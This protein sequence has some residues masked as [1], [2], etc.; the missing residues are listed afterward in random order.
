VAIKWRALAAVP[1]KS[2]NNRVYSEKV[3]RETVGQWEG[4]PFLL[5]HD[6]H[7]VR[8][9]CVGIISHSNYGEDKCRDGST[10]KGL[11][12]EGFG[13]VSKPLFE[14]MQDNPQYPAIV[15]STSI[16]AAGEG[17]MFN[18]FGG[19]T[20]VV[21]DRLMPEEFSC[22]SIPGIPESHLASVD[23]IEEAYRK[24][25][26]FN[27]G[28]TKLSEQDNRTDGNTIPG[29]P[30]A[31]FLPLGTG[32]P[33]FNPPPTL[34]PTDSTTAQHAR[35]ARGEECFRKAPLKRVELSDGSVVCYQP[36]TAIEG[37]RP[38]STRRSELPS[39][40][41]NWRGPNVL[42]Q[43]ETKFPVDNT[44]L[45]YD[46]LTHKTT[47]VKREQLG[48]GGNTLGALGLGRMS[49]QPPA[50]K[51]QFG[52]MGPAGTGP[53]QPRADT[54]TVMSYGQIANMAPGGKMPP[55]PPVKPVD[56]P[57]TAKSMSAGVNVGAIGGQTPP[58]DDDTTAG[59][60]G[61][62]ETKIASSLFYDPEEYLTKEEEEL[63]DEVFSIPDE[64]WANFE[65]DAIVSMAEGSVHEW[66][67]AKKKN[68]IAGAI[69]HP[70]ALRKA[71]GV[72][73]DEPIPVSRLQ[74]AAK[75]KDPKMRRRAI[76]A[77]TLRKLHRK[78]AK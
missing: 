43:E 18:T 71:L 63:L 19:D 62:S 5:D 56:I 51:D 46:P 47:E 53:M 70:G 41:T 34:A 75:S 13:R 69:R 44:V 45:Q 25:N 54:P 50:V 67:E 4:K 60:T 58:S 28:E 72:K 49:A 6:L 39:A 7:D 12:L 16:G 68:W 27:F 32:A 38:M 42:K 29:S 76:L 61:R 26:L 11:W 9:K 24:G 66:I 10:K 21:I 35:G 48:M 30:D 3:L 40:M 2:R 52:G 64:E 73:G 78:R 74:A 77:L 31:K 8:E 55:Y 37:R 20:G 36:S 57:R 23:R 65:M 17:K 1:G 33:Y 59:D 22:V 15:K 14:R